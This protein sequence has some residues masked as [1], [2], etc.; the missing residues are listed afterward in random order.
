M[1]FKMSKKDWNKII[2]FARA[3]E[4]ETGDEIGGMA[5]VN[6]VEDDYVISEPVILKQETTG[7]TCTLD[8]EALADYY[9]RMANKHGKDVN[10]MWWHSHAKMKAFWS[11]TDTST[12]DDYN[13]GKWS[14]FLV[15]N[16]YEEYKFRITVWE[17]QEMYIDTELEIEGQEE[18]KIPASIRKQV[19]EKCS[20][21]TVVT[22]IHSN[23][24]NHYGNQRSL[25]DTN[26]EMKDYNQSF[27][28]MTS[29]ITDKVDKYNCRMWAMDAV[30]EFNGTY[31]MGECTYEDY[32]KE[33][34]EAN[35]EIHKVNKDVSIKLIPEQQLFEAIQHKHAYDF[36]EDKENVNV[37]NNQIQW[38]C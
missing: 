25:W 4:D 28:N 7:A 3:R 23:K 26:M 1:A 33:V 24:Y 16:V 29:Y 15:V 19:T 9:I 13:N 11:G 32:V 2:N 17:P 37:S 21:P 35:K 27:G 8:K 30:D 22:S 14:V 34:K 12:M 38:N 6:K 5:V 31:I 36:I 10:F 18:F 20:K